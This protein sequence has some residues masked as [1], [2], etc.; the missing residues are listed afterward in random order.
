MVGIQ[1]NSTHRHRAGGC[2]YFLFR[3]SVGQSDT[4]RAKSLHLHNRFA[5]LYAYYS[6]P[7]RKIKEEN[8]ILFQKFQIL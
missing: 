8:E 7:L 6:I 4:A 3:F 2:S 5:S 1:E